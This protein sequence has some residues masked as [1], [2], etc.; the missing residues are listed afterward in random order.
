MS[1]P[2]LSSV[3]HSLCTYVRMYVGMCIT[4]ASESDSCILE[5]VALKCGEYEEDVGDFT[6]RAVSCLCDEGVQH[7]SCLSKQCYSAMENSSQCQ[8]IFT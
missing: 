2:L 5:S 3:V 6:L 4:I 7:E 1:H 8:Y